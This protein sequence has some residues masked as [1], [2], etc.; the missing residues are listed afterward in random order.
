MRIQQMDR[1]PAETAKRRIGLCAALCLAAFLSNAADAQC[2]RQDLSALIDDYLS[3][4][5][6]NAPGRLDL[7]SD[8]KYT[9]S[10]YFL[11]V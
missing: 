6:A 7:A 11:A 5:S 4:L 8:V 1:I 3:A 2:A 10:S 9:E